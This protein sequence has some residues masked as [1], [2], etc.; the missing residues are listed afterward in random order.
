MA[1]KK[2]TN[3]KTQTTQSEAPQAPEGSKSVR[4]AAADGYFRVAEN[5]FIQGIAM[6]RYPRRNDPGFYYQV[7]LTKPCASVQKK[8]GEGGYYD[9][10][11]EIGEVISVDERAV[12]MGLQPYV[13]EAPDKL[14]EV[15]IC[16]EEKEKQGSRSFWRGDARIVGVYT[17]ANRDDDDG[18]PF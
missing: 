14:Y 13:E 2:K 7:K 16:F 18:L 1:A 3:K 6:G 10:D 11:A 15:W 4:S 8:D 12:M 5:T 17:S 9:T